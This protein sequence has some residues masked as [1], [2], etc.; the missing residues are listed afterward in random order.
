MNYRGF[1]KSEGKIENQEQIL[2]DVKIIF[3]KIT[4]QYDNKIII[5]YSIGTGIA[6]D[7]ASKEKAKVLILQAPYDNFLSFTE[8]KAPYFPNSFKKFQFETDK[9][10]PKIKYPIYIFHGNKDQLIPIEN[11]FR[12]KKMFKPTDSLFILDNQEH[13]GINENMDYQDKLKNILK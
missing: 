8:S 10:F 11:S 9:C 1:G 6:A 13:N 4:K 5:G 3:D 2:K 12:L 7:L